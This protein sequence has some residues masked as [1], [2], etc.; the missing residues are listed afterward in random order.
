M[1]NVEWQASEINKLTQQLLE[2]TQKFCINPTSWQLVE[3]HQTLDKIKIHQQLLTDFCYKELK[4]E[5]M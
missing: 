2:I 5:K 4:N 3:I 1:E